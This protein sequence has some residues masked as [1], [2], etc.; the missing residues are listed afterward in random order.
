MLRG[1]DEEEKYAFGMNR[2][3]SERAKSSHFKQKKNISSVPRIV[4]ESL[5]WYKTCKGY[6]QCL[7][8]TLVEEND[9]LCNLHSFY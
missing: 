9:R 2:D 1:S 7:P 4:F 6:E 3:W 5:S 8:Q